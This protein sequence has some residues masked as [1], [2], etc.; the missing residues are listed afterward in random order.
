MNWQEEYQKWIDNEK[1]DS[2]LRTQ[3]INIAQDEKL[4]EDSFYQNMAFGTAGMRGV[5]GAGT[6][7]MNIYTIRKATDGLARYVAENGAEAKQRGVVIAYDPRHMSQ[8]FAYESAAVLG[9]HGIKSYVFEALRPTPELSFAVRYLN[10]FSGIMITASHNP[11][12]YNGYKVYGED[13]GQMPPQGADAVTSYINSIHDIFSVKTVDVEELKATGML[14][15]ISDK[16]DIPYLEKLK[17]VTVNQALVSEKGKELKIVFTPLHGTGGVLGVPALENAGFTNIIKVEEQFVNDP[18]FGTVKSPN[19]ENHEAFELAMQYGE[20]YDGD[21]LVGTDPDADRLGVA[22]RKSDGEYQVFTGNQIGAL[23]LNYLLKQKKNQNELPKNAAV[24][25]SIVTSDLGKAIADHYD[26]QMIEVLTGFKFIAEQIKNFEE[27]GSHTFEFGYEESNGYMLKPFTRDKDAIQAVLAISEV[28][29]DAKQRGK[30]L[31]DE[32]DD[33][34][35]QF[36]Y[37]KEDLVSLTMSGKDGSEKIAAIMAAFRDSLPTDMGGVKVARV[38]D[39]LRRETTFVAT[40]ETAPIDLPRADVLK[41]YMEDG[42]WFCLRPSG[43]EPKI[44]FYFSVKA[45]TP[46]NSLEK[47]DSIRD[48]LVA[49]IEK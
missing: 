48:D 2:E 34:F 32:L 35:E 12:E 46:E 19:P 28:A 47:L 40:G 43:T 8:E 38:E 26:V 15:V 14:E 4:L 41:F 31:A 24:L 42:S 18:D 1:L 5:L 21:I 29:L 9:A 10:C 30:N 7:R 49:R 39:Y 20:K 11:P 16:V 17:E 13:G 23:I 22:V 25:K 44:K 6:N 37:Y 36:G 33:I 3:L 27:S 45:D